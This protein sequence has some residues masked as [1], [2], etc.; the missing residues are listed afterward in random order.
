MLESQMAASCEG[1]VESSKT[2]LQCVKML[3]ETWPVVYEFGE[4]CPLCPFHPSRAWRAP[5]S[6]SPHGHGS[7]LERSRINHAKR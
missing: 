7:T 6:I 5:C 4:V 1:E 2:L 3:T